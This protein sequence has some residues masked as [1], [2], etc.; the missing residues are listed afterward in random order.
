MTQT[1]FEQQLR[2]AL[3]RGAGRV[4]PSPDH[5][6]VRVVRRNRARGRR[7]AGM[8]ALGAAGLAMILTLPMLLAG[9]RSAVITSRPASPPSATNIPSASSGYT[10]P[11]TGAGGST[12]PTSQPT[13][14]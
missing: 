11:S 7:R 3:R 13:A 8:I 4:T 12:P 2:N 6:W 5:A 14:A 1:E 9:H 10:P